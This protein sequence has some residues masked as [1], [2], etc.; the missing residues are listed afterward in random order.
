MRRL[1]QFIILW[2]LPLILFG[3]NVIVQQTPPN[4]IVIQNNGNNVTAKPITNNVGIASSGPQGTAGVGVPTGGT[5]GQVLSKIDST[6]YNTQWVNQT[7]GGGT[8][9]SITGTLSNQTD[10][11]TA[12]NGK[13]ASGSYLTTEIDPIF[14]ASSAYGITGANITS[15]NAKQAAL[16]GTGFV[17]FSGTTPSYDNSTYL[18]TTSASSTYV[19]F[20]GGGADV[21]LGAHNLNVGGTFTANNL[22]GTNTGDETKA[23][24]KTKLGT[25][26]TSTDGYLTSTDWNTFKNGTLWTQGTGTLAPITTSNRLLV[27]GATDDGSTAIQ[28]LGAVGAKNANSTLIMGDTTGNARGSY[29]LD[30]Q[31]YRDTGSTGAP[32]VA[33]GNYVT[34]VGIQNTDLSGS[35]SDTIVGAANV[36][37]STVGGNTC[38]GMSNTVNGATGLFA[39]GTY[40]GVYGGGAV[41][42]SLNTYNSSSYSIGTFFN[43]CEGN[44]VMFG[45]AQGAGGSPSMSASSTEVKSL[46]PDISIANVNTASGGEFVN[47]PNFNYGS[48]GTEM[49]TSFAAGNWTLT[50]GWDATNGGGTQLNHNG[51]GTTTATLTGVAAVIGT[52]YRVAF[53]V[54]TRTGASGFGISFGGVSLITTSNNTG[55][56]GDGTGVFEASIVATS[57]AGLVVTPSASA[58]NF[59]IN[60]IS[61]KTFNWA[62]TSIWGFQENFPSTGFAASNWTLPT[63]WDATNGGGTQLNHN[64][65]GS[66]AAVFNFLPTPSVYYRVSLHI[67]SLTGGGCVISHGSLPVGTFTS[68]GYYTVDVYTNYAYG[69]TI[70]P[71]N[72]TDTFVIDRISIRGYNAMQKF[73][74]GTA[75]TLIQRQADMA[76]AMQVGKLYLLTY[77]LGGYSYNSSAQSITTNAGGNSSAMPPNPGIT[78]VGTV[79]YRTF[80]CTSTSTNLSVAVGGTTPPPLFVL[81]GFSIKQLGDA[82]LNVQGPIKNN[83]T[84][85][86]YTGSTGGSAVWSQ[87]FQGIAYKKFIINM[88][89]L[90]DAGGTVTYPTAFTAT[91]YIYG[92]TTPLSKCTTNTTTL[93]ITATGGAITGNVFVEGY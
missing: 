51:S 2:I 88:A 67:A 44:T 52:T 81:T 59:T 29:C 30:L 23:T 41:G 21:D 31:P 39:V 38:V 54:P 53:T 40:N 58:N 28:I 66:S 72:P 43:N 56:N 90:N 60:A 48:L 57:T 11:Q 79:L 16:S 74:K 22:S 71:V 27:G 13:Q 32:Q 75:G 68:A 69:L 26:S 15:W 45:A 3:G 89:A 82:N 64:A 63:G 80:R 85:T 5:A 12:L 62:F 35:T 86:T 87:P 76:G 1:A 34:I 19:P 61:I 46:T 25:S 14:A 24:I 49:F 70:S 33:A 73:P 17:K 65:S 20:T 42:S 50:G 92:D 47:N 55:S 91:P 77:T 4:N 10:L 83:V 36:V 84:Q 37:G 7:G 8:W 9:G 18:T 6:N 93:T 78:A